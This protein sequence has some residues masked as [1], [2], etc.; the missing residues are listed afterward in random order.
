MR[1]NVYIDESGIGRKFGAT[2]YCITVCYNLDAT[3][4][5][6]KILQ[7]EK[8]LRV[9]PFHWREHSWTVK[10]KF[11]DSILGIEH[12]S[13][14]TVVIKNDKFNESAVEKLLAKAIQGLDVDKMYIDG[15]KP[16]KYI[17]LVKK[18]FKNIG[19]SV[20]KLK[21]VRHQSAGGLRVSDAVAGLVRL[22]YDGKSK[23]D[24]IK[25][26]KRFLNKK[27]TTQILSGY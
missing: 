2:V 17:N 3:D 22:H 24:A 9:P 12:W 5:D 8:S 15:K 18:S 23:A 21:M 26:Y 10:T 19:I 11:L 13:C 20:S 7:I 4:L 6:S 16:R 1:V 14:M 27:I 25:F